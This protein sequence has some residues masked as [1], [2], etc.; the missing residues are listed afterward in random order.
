MTG[1]AADLAVI[2][3]GNVLR[4]DDAVGVRVVEGLRA[5]LAADPCAM[6]AQTRLVDGG[7]LGLDLLRSI[8]DARAVVLV[9]AVHLGASAGTVSVLRGED[10]DSPA[11][12]LVGMNPGAVSE[13]VAVARMLGWLPAEVALVGIEVADTGVGVGMSSAV[14]D[15]LPVAMEVVGAELHRM[16]LVR[17]TGTAG[18][19]ATARLAG[20]TA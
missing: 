2:G 9:D 8:R 10:I 17:A 4:G 5:V 6:R 12:P 18:D 19:R 11:R 1:P 20:A 14:T 3:V 16:N 13:L 15:A 7:T